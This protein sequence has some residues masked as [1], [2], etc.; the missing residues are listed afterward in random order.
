MTMLG[1]T[2]ARLLLAVGLTILLLTPV[3]R[4]DPSI[5]TGS[6]GNLDV[7]WNLQNPA[8][9]TFNGTELQGGQVSLMR[10]QAW[11]NFTTQADF[12]TYTSAT[13]VNLTQRPGDILLDN[14]STS[15]NASYLSSVVGGGTPA[16]WSSLTWRSSFVV[17]NL[18]DDF[19][20]T[21]LANKW[22]WLNPPSSYAVGSPRPGYLTFTSLSNTNFNNLQHSGQ[23][24]YENLTGDFQVEVHLNTTLST[25]NQKVG[26]LAMADL[27]DW[28]GLYRRLSSANIPLLRTV[29]TNGGVTIINGTLNA[30]PDY[31]R[32][33]RVGNTL[34]T[35]YSFDGKTWNSFV[36]IGPGTLPP[37][38]WVG[39]MA[40]DSAAGSTV[41]VSV[42]YIHFTFPPPTVQLST[43]TGNATATSDPSWTP[44][45]P[46]LPDPN[47][48]AVDRQGKYLQYTIALTTTSPYVRPLISEVDIAW[49][50][51]AT[52]GTI[53]TQALAPGKATLWT[54]LAVTDDVAGGTIDPSYSTDGG[55]TWA[56]V[57]WGVPNVTVGQGLQLRLTLSAP[58]AY[59]SPT[60]R[61]LRIVLEVP[62]TLPPPGPGPTPLPWWPLL[63]PLALVPVVG[64]LLW[65]RRRSFRPTDL[66]LIHTDGRLVLRVGGKDS[67]MKDDTA[68]SAMF[69]LMDR[70]VRDSF[71]GA[72]GAEGSLKSL[73]VDQR[74]VAIAKG[75]YLFLALVA[76]GKRPPGLDATMVRFLR[77]LEEQAL[78]LRSWD[79]L[80]DDLAGVGERLRWFLN[81]GYRRTRSTSPAGSQG[82]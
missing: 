6:Q 5:T 33:K 55:A 27:N 47:G 16:H 80:D 60:V 62:A 34:E 74:E 24:L 51:Y 20:G 2:R 19:N 43:R 21:S 81:R 76:E 32:I 63:L 36:N 12:G 61:E 10:T 15:L 64:F 66:F 22:T 50:A 71:G 40:A 73:R 13:N 31:L 69:T 23:F 29:T 70:F 8:N 17:A 41:T 75:E 72:Q 3:A 7:V 4:G 46:P 65:R 39:V 28:Y 26:L 38:L 67:P 59:A 82:R 52:R 42:D 35:W 14:T 30:A 44:W 54:L 53:L 25:S 11:S 45:S 48:S 56:A 68:V 79:G 9:Y 78:F 77:A 49:E 1:R 57:A 58:D 18:S 37:Y